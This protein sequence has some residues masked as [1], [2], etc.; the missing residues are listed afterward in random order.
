MHLM[1]TTGTVQ[2]VLTRGQPKTKYTKPN[3][4]SMMMYEHLVPSDFAL[5]TQLRNREEA[6]EF[7]LHQVDFDD[8][9]R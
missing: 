6:S 9:R 1:Q 4:P 8:E 3:T 2:G 7:I 5:L